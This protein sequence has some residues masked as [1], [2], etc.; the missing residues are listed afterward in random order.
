MSMQLP[1]HAER[2]YGHMSL[3]LLIKQIN[4]HAKNE[5]YVTVP[6]SQPSTR[7]ARQRD[8]QRGGQ[9]GGRGGRVGGVPEAMTSV[10]QV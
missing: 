6:D 1:P 8:S 9:R 10:F 7:G 3:D 2:C 4:E 5:G